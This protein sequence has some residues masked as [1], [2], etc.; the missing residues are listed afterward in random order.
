M[1]QRIYSQIKA[2]RSL[3]VAAAMVLFILTLIG[4]QLHAAPPSRIV[5]LGVEPTAVGQVYLRPGLVSVFEYPRSIKEVRVGNAGFVKVLIS[6]VSPRELTVLMNSGSE[7]TNLIVRDEKRIYVLDL[8]P[9]K[10]THQD[11]VRIGQLAFKS[12]KASPKAKSGAGL[13]G[14]IGGEK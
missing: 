11:F 6:T 9:S 8:I 4:F 13:H 1:C 10:F 14:P 2:T 12:D 7:P 3:Q 5:R